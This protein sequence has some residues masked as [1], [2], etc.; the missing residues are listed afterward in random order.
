MYLFLLLVLLLGTAVVT[1]GVVIY[2]S[3]GDYDLQM[4]DIEEVP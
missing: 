3:M 2:R 1:A 4:P